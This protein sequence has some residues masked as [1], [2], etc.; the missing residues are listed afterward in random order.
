MPRSPAQRSGRGYSGTGRISE[1]RA[2]YWRRRLEAE[3]RGGV[4]PSAGG[5]WSVEATLRVLSPVWGPPRAVRVDFPPGPGWVDSPT[6]A[7][8]GRAAAEHVRDAYDDLFPRRDRAEQERR[9]AE[10]DARGVPA[11]IAATREREAEEV[12]VAAMSDDDD[13]AL[14]GPLDPPG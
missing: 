12:A 13:R 1:H 6:Y 3:Q 14:F 4:A 2:D 9:W 8:H 5:G 11:E 7:A 10:Q